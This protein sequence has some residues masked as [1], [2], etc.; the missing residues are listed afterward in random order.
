[1]LLS[2]GWLVRVQV[3]D[4]QN[5]ALEMLRHTRKR[6]DT[7][8]CTARHPH[9]EHLFIHLIPPTMNNAFPSLLRLGFSAS[10]RGSLRGSLFINS[11][12]VNTKALQPI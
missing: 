4:L 2:T 3:S 6:D 1:M 9:K 10:L 7:G 8:A 12:A 5:S 11:S